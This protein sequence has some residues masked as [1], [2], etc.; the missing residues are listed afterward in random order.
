M[1]SRDVGVRR[2]RQRWIN[3]WVHTASA[4]NPKIAKKILTKELI[5]GL[6]VFNSGLFF[7][8][9]KDTIFRK[10]IDISIIKCTNKC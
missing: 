7:P 4:P 5:Q 8:D 9:I 3:L 2:E 10:V 6:F 1:V